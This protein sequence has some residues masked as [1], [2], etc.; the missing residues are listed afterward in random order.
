MV[1][2]SSKCVNILCLS[3]LFFYLSVVVEEVN[4]F[5]LH[6]ESYMTSL[7]VGS[8][9]SYENLPNAEKP[10]CNKEIEREEKKREQKKGPTKR[11]KSGEE[12][13]EEDPGPSSVSSQKKPTKKPTFC[14]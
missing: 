9:K 3:V 12:R 5:F 7:A 11:R 1:S 6:S 4:V 2:K 8:F 14:E 13:D 10:S